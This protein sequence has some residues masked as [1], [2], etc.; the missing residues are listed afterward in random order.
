MQFIKL[1]PTLPPDLA[2][3]ADDEIKGTKSIVFKSLAPGKPCR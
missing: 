2:D 3:I 1:A